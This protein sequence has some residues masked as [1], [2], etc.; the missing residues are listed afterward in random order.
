MSA[1]EPE[2]ALTEVAR[3]IDSDAALGALT[4]SSSRSLRA[5]TDELHRAVQSLLA[6]HPETKFLYGAEVDGILLPTRGS[7]T[8]SRTAIPN[9][10]LGSTLPASL[11]SATAAD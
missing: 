3:R 6:A 1:A 4:E 9:R 5:S 7:G 8:V 2:R 11:R 10:C